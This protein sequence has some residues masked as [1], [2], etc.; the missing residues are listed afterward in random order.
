[1]DIRKAIRSEEA[2]PNPSNY[3]HNYDLSYVNN[4]FYT[5]CMSSMPNFDHHMGFIKVED[6]INM[7]P[8]PPCDVYDNNTYDSLLSSSSIVSQTSYGN[9]NFFTLDGDDDGNKQKNFNIEGK[10][11][12]Q[13]KRSLKD[14]ADSPTVIKK[15]RLAANARERRRMNGLNEAFD[16]LRNVIPSLDAEHKLSKFETLQMAQSYIAALKEL[17]N[18]NR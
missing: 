8:P 4:N 2:D 12:K 1:M 6:A 18:L 13:K 11:K 5:R 7:T 10:M 16:R 9:F 3:Y 17:L 15:R 14:R